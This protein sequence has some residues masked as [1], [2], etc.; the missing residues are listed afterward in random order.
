MNRLDLPASYAVQIDHTFLTNEK[1][2]LLH[3]HRASGLCELDF[4]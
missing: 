2:S 1:K 3:L 4:G